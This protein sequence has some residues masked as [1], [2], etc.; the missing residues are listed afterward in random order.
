[1]QVL[2]G[3]KQPAEGRFTLDGKQPERT[4]AEL[5]VTVSKKPRQRL[6]TASRVPSVKQRC[7]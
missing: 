2:S 6:G 1:M 3:P 7:F 5:V 4:V